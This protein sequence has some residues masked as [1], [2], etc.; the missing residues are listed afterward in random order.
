MVNPFQ[1]FLFFL[2]A[3]LNQVV[4]LAAGCAVTVFIGIIEKRVLK[5][6][7]SIK[8]ES[9]I[10]LAFIFFACFQTWRD[11]YNRANGLQTTLN[12]KPSQP[13]VL[14]NVPPTQV[15]IAHSAPLVNAD[16]TGLLQLAGLEIVTKSIVKGSPIFIDTKYMVKGTQPIHGTYIAESAILADYHKIPDEETERTAEQ[17]LRKIFQKEIQKQK[18][19][20]RQ[21]KVEGQKFGVGNGFAWRTVSTAPLSDEQAAGIVNGQTRLYL[22]TWAIWKD[23]RNK[24]ADLET[25][26][27]LQAPSST[28]LNK[29]QLVWHVCVW[30]P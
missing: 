26:E 18:L 10:F 23:S 14:I 8:L 12:Q 28:D 7:I 13:P 22:M 21:K 16:L 25:C 20:I 5:R 1:H 11:Q 27:W 24:N 3:V 19:T 6:P 17:E 15:V 2:W 29:E 9:G 4:T 30:A